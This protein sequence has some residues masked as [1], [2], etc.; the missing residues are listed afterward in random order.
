MERLQCKFLCIV[1]IQVGKS[2]GNNKKNKGLPQDTNKQF[3]TK[4]FVKTGNPRY[5]RTKQKNNLF[6]K[7]TKY[8]SLKLYS[9]ETE[10]DAQACVLLVF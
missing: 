4:Y 5:F 2:Y 1:G 6:T 7:V 8:G 10:I 9:F 3:F